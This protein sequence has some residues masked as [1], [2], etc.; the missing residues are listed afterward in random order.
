MKSCA[1][2]SKL[3][4]NCSHHAGLRTQTSISSGHISMA[5]STKHCVKFPIRE[6]LTLFL[7]FFWQSKILSWLLHPWICYAWLKNIFIAFAAL[8]SK[9]QMSIPIQ[10]GL[11]QHVLMPTCNIPTLCH[12][13]LVCFALG[14]M[15]T[16]WN[17]SVNVRLWL[18]LGM[19]KVMVKV[20]VRAAIE[21][22]ETNKK[23][24]N[25]ICFN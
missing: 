11:V 25:T 20:R 7:W 9:V 3:F 2:H 5:E 16:G 21:S 12:K 19:D 18:R 17:E 6:W 15:R 8:L 22:S 10:S 4:W 1:F 13:S 14:G 23:P 24:S